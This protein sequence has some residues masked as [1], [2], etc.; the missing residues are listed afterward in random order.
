MPSSFTLI[1][2]RTAIT[3]F[4][5]WFCC[6]KTTALCNLHSA[7]DP[8]L[9]AAFKR[10]DKKSRGRKF[11]FSECQVVRVSSALRHKFFLLTDT[12]EI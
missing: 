4:Y 11:T 6:I 10:G 7:K 8:F 3:H 2:K 12:R 1:F 5:F 9:P